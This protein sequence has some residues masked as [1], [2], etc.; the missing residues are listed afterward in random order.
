MFT[1]W[2]DIPWISDI[3]FEIRVAFI[4]LIFNGLKIG[5][6]FKSNT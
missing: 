5:K 1:S 6:V 2:L 3:G 4:T